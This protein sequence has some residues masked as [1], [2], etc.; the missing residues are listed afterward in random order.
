M[1]R[2]CSQSPQVEQLDNS[3]V[4]DVDIS[5]NLET[6]ETKSSRS[7]INGVNTSPGRNATDQTCESQDL[8]SHHGS[9]E[10][11]LGKSR[12][13]SQSPLV[14]PQGPDA[15]I[16]DNSITQEAKSARP[17]IN[18]VN[19]SSGGNAADQTCEPQDLA[20]HY[21][22]SESYLGRSKSHSHPPLVEQT[23]KSQIRSTAQTEEATSE[24]HIIDGVR[25]IYITLS[26]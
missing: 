21:G 9:S 26:A 1:P 19:T 3:Q 11:C 10:S 8:A 12:S 25:C 6:E 17:A 24:R 16:S 18:G 22:S 2:S 4:P 15:G 20:S 7:A 14:E 23:D 13:H 5:D